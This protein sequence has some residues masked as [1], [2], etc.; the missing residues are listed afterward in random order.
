MQLRSHQFAAVDAV[1][2]EYRSLR[3]GD[4]NA[5]VANSDG[6]RADAGQRAGL[7]GRGAAPA[8]EGAESWGRCAKL[9]AQAADKL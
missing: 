3:E 2:A 4:D 7:P 5:C 8:R 1:E 6:G 9:L